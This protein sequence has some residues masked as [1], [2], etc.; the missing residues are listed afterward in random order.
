MR[1]LA[2]AL[3]LILTLVTLAHAAAPTLPWTTFS[4][5]MVQAVVGSPQ[6]GS[7]NGTEEQ[8]LFVAGFLDRKANAIFVM[9][10][11]PANNRIIFMY[12]PNPG[13]K[14]APPTMIGFGHVDPA[15]HDEIPPL[16][17]VPFD[18]DVHRDV[19]R[20]MFRSEA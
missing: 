19:C 3:V 14:N 5:E 9:I 11:A 6:M 2:A 20:M 7:C 10:Y 17:W 15:K 4:G 13:D 12:D 8:A 1:K 18:P 16:L